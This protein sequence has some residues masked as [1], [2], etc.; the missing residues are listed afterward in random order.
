MCRKIREVL[1]LLIK[2][3]F[4]YFFCPPVSNC[5]I[6]VSISRLSF[7]LFC[8]SRRV[9]VRRKSHS[10]WKQNFQSCSKPSGHGRQ[11]PTMTL[12]VTSVINPSQ[13]D[14]PPFL[15]TET[16]SIPEFFDSLKCLIL[17]NIWYMNCMCL[18]K[19][20]LHTH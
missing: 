19:F 9:T 17:L 13:M 8:H 2:L 3:V 15:N 14:E 18:C 5:N 12:I 1:L 11:M 16:V 20:K 6:K 10:V 7:F 4:V